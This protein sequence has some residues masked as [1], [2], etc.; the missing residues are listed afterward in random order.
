MKQEQIFELEQ[1]LR[2][3]Y[4]ILKH[5]IHTIFRKE[6][7]QSEFTIL[8]LLS[9]NQSLKASDL[10]KILNVSASHIT[11]VTD[12]LVKKGY[13]KRKRS[14]VDRRVVDM[15]VTDI[16]KSLIKEFGEKKSEYFYS[17]LKRFS[18]DEMAEFVRLLNKLK[19]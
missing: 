12:S 11:S 19:D 5:D 17:K 6:I 7:S 14:E 10:S 2:T 3:V 4:R 13:L 15:I 16:G 9:R 8:K 18:D 1:L